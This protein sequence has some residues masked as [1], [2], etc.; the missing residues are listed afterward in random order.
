MRDEIAKKA[1]RKLL[2][3]FIILSG[4][5]HFNLCSL[6]PLDRIKLIMIIY[7]LQFNWL[8]DENDSIYSSCFAPIFR[9][10]FN[11]YLSELHESL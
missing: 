3:T 2:V 4:Y 10:L 8:F 11:L 1:T 5:Q 9:V 7:A 6:I